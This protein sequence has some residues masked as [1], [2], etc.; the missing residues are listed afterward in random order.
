MPS[1]LVI[2]TETHHTL[3][4][5]F[6]MSLDIDAHVGSMRQSK[7]RAIAGITTGRIGL[8]QKVT[9]RARHFG[10]WITMTSTISELR[11][12][13]YF[14][15]SQVKGPF[16]SFNHRH[17]FVREGQR[18]V[19]TD[20]LTVESPLGGKLVER[21]FLVP[22]VRHLIRLRNEHLLERLG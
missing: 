5:L 7:E 19:M 15:D 3:E 11:R 2:T 6:D 4:E 20:T 9:W 21:I 8:G 13:D 1:T 16:R 10:V 18:T 22:Y 17:D 12:P 14:V